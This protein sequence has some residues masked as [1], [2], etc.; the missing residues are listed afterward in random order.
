MV[1]FLII[2]VVVAVVVIFLLH[3]KNQPLRPGD[4]PSTLPVAKQENNQIAIHELQKASVQI[5]AVLPP[6]QWLEDKSSGQKFLCRT[7]NPE[8]LSLF[9]Q[10]GS[11]VSEYVH[12]IAFNSFL[13][14]IP[15][16]VA[17]MRGGTVVQ[18]LGPPNL[19]SGLKSGIYHTVESGGH[20]GS[21]AN[22]NGQIVGNLRFGNP[23]NIRSFAVPAAIF[24][25]ASAVTLQYYLHQMNDKLVSIQQGIENLIQREQND[26][27][28]KIMAA[29]TTCEEIRGILR[30][31]HLPDSNDQNK[32]NIANSQINE[33]YDK[34]RKSI[35]DFDNQVL[36]DTNGEKITQMAGL[37]VDGSSDR[38]YDAQLTLA[39]IAVRGELYHL[40]YEMGLYL[41][42]ERLEVNTQKL[43]KQIADM[44][45]VYKQ[46]QALYKRL[47][48]LDDIVE[49]KSRW[50]KIGN[51]IAFRNSDFKK[52]K[53]DYQVKTQGLRDTIQQSF[54]EQDINQPFLIECRMDDNGNIE[55]R[56]AMIAVKQ[57]PR[58]QQAK[59]KA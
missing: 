19:I 29:K 48:G 57:A 36:K 23:V 31:G 34:C 59:F 27:Y 13:Q 43:E 9:Q 21:V 2:L 45:T 39:S 18:I 12:P 37:L 28:A 17:A 38:L 58:R 50:Q 47:D 52:K 32:I 24:Q 54:P 55:S 11:Q 6:E 5:K 26:Q 4:A 56:Y 20:L 16:V 7:V 33:A 51:T 22:S 3:R 25:V 30:S 41:Y 1:E 53:K 14:S 15:N 44:K 40:E 46:I 42:P 35:N 49:N 10:N 8:D